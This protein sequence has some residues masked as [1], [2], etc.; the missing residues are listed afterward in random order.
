MKTL[1]T[2]FRSGSFDFK[3]L[4]RDGHIALLRKT[5]PGL[6]FETFEVV[7]VQHHKER[8][9]AG[10]SI[11]GGEAMPSSE[12]WGSKGWTF[13]DKTSAERK[14]KLLSTQKHSRPPTPVP[15][16]LILPRN[17]KPCSANQST[18]KWPSWRQI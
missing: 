15:A 16:L 8:I 18:K 5:K 6:A 14:A 2:A 10:K 12:Q 3:L 9:I 13:S 4:V 1:P 17:K 11:E 7:V